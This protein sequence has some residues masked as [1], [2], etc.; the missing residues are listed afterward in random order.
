[1][2]VTWTLAELAERAADELRSGEPAPASSN[3]RVRDVPSARLI[4]WYTTI[5][6]VDPPLTR[7]GRVALYGERHLLQLVAVK[8]LQA[9]GRSIAEIQRLLAGAT[10]DRLAEVVGPEARERFWATAPVPAPVPVPAPAPEEAQPASPAAPV[11][12]PALR[13][14]PGVTLLVD[15]AP[16]T[17]DAA[18]LAELAEAA[19][20]LLATLRA[21]GLTGADTSAP[22]SDPET[23]PEGSAS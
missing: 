9:R 13:L 14:A 1:M 22:E 4:R 10:D 19:A 18:D 3:G 7:R 16:R 11:V 23:D 8:R 2:A 5:G 17:P 6:L 21:R 12:V 20:P 15:G